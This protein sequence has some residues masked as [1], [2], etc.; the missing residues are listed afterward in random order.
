[1]VRYLTTT[2]IV[3]FMLLINELSAQPTKLNNVLYG[4][5]YYHEYMPSERLDEDI[6]MMKEANIT[7]V[8]VGESSWGLFEPRDGV[9]EF[10]WMD[11]ILDKMD[12]AGIK[13]ILGTPTYSMPA[14][15]AKAHPEVLVKFLGGTQAFYGIR[16]NMDYTNPAFLF[17]ADRIIRK[18]M[19]R[20]AKHPA[21]IGYQ[22]DNETTSYGI[23]NDGAF[24]GFVNYM[25]N[26]YKSLDNLNKAW[27]N[28]YWGMNINSWEEFPTRDGATNPSY[29]LEWERYK[30]KIIA[31]YLIWQSK[32]VR[33]YSKPGQFIT[34][35]YMPSI[36]DIDH[37]ASSK[38]MDVMAVNVYHPQQNELTGVEIAFVGDYFRG[39]KNHNYLVTETNAQTTSWSSQGQKPPY[40]GQLR[41]NVFAH[42][43]SG[44]NMVEYWHWHSN[45]TGQETYW[46][47][48]LSHDLQPNRA[49]KEV[50]G[51]AKELKAIGPHLVNLKKTNKAAILFSHD[52][53]HAIEFMKYSNAS[54]AYTN[55]WLK[56]M[57]EALYKQNV[58]TD[59]ILPQDDFS[60]YELLVVPPLYIASDSLLERINTYVRNGGHVLMAMKSGFANEHNAVRATLAPG[61]LR[62]AAGFHYQ[63]FGNIDPT[64]LKGNPY[65][66]KAD[67]N[68]VQDWAEFLTLESAKPLAFYDDKHW[69]KYPA[70][71][72][73]AYGKGSL[74]YIGTV[75]SAELMDS[76]IKKVVSYAGI[77]APAQK[78]G[79]PIIVR[80]GVN[81]YGKRI[82]Y[83][84]NYSDGVVST[85][86]PYNDGM[87]L[88][89]DQQIKANAQLKL[90]PW[91]VK[92]IEEKLH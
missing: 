89:D 49:F 58:E 72:V 26:K 65:Q 23:N 51:V 69:G 59:I 44:A 21:I 19:E 52:S 70:V 73:N 22:V 42:L 43:A 60:K 79:F 53:Y 18:L 82:H 85:N 71:T 20:Y 91:G 31:D 83:F 39:F 78:L 6:R 55:Q 27:G 68:K 9:F 35:C 64:P 7:V 24:V 77:D 1:M 40:D 45:H 74:T 12:K 15:L 36:Q 76:V 2:F 28:N 63:E 3:F 5:A 16:Q 57:H 50:S 88:L 37:V 90:A 81:D 46:K 61:P 41:M 47:G 4:V 80:S 86:Y 8:R 10:A 66:V 11:R 75:L 30:R 13:V 92:I 54:G 29:K 14:W 38:Y 32:I 17:Y 56:P 34:Q 84:F 62:K 48:V 87:E 33:E 67:N 25:K